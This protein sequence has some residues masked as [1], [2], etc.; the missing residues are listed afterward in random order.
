M[1]ATL[2][3][4]VLAL[5]PTSMLFL[6]SLVLFLKRRGLWSSM[7]LGGSACFIIVIMTHVVEALQLLPSMHWG[8]ENSMGHYLDL[9]SALGGLTL[10]PVGYL[11]QALRQPPA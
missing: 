7:Q 3:R 9:V 2:F 11:F 5:I 8:M 6:G 4:T 10:F 1:N